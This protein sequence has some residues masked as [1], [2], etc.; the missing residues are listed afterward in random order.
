MSAP[1]I[2]R[3]IDGKFGIAEG[4]KIVNL[5]SGAEIPPDEPLFL[6]RA[7]DH[8]SYDT[9]IHYLNL[10]TGECN[11]LH[12]A[13]IKQTI[14]KFIDFANTHPERMKQPGVTRDLKLEGA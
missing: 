7:R 3:V 8:N 11:Q 2:L 4:G 13:G 6:L 1:T 9:L 12:L 14:R 10:C 5:V